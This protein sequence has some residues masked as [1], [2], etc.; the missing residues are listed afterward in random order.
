MCPSPGDTGRPP[1]IAAGRRRSQ[2]DRSWA[3]GLS[4]ICNFR[5]RR[6]SDWGKTHERRQGSVAKCRY[7]V[8]RP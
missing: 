7:S 4:Q 1:G 6:T 3:P 8:A 5:C 2:G